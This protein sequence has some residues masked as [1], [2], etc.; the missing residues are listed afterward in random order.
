MMKISLKQQLV[1][2]SKLQ[3]HRQQSC[4][5]RNMTVESMGSSGHHMRTNVDSN[6]RSSPIPESTYRSGMTVQY[7]E[8][9][10]WCVLTCL[11]MVFREVVEWQASGTLFHTC[12][13][14]SARSPMVQSCKWHCQLMESRRSQTLSGVVVASPV[15]VSCH[16]CRLSALCCCDSR[17]PV[18]LVSVLSSVARQKW[19]PAL[20]LQNSKW[21]CWVCMKAARRWTYG[22]TQLALSEE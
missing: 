3:D 20:W 9:I 4:K 1:E 22:P 14:T 7:D 5:I 10:Y 8:D 19:L 16:V 2:S 13:A 11:L 12:A 18:W 6:E 21:Q 17:R 15:Q